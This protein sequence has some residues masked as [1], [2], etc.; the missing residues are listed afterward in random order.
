MLY[1]NKFSQ[2]IIESSTEDDE[3]IRAYNDWK[4]GETRK[5]DNVYRDLPDS[6]ATPK[7]GNYTLKVIPI[8]ETDL[9]NDFARVGYGAR[10]KGDEPKVPALSREYWAHD[11]YDGYQTDQLDM[12]KQGWDTKNRLPI[13]VEETNDNQYEVIDGHH[14]LTIAKELGKKTILALVKNKDM[15]TEDILDPN[16]YLDDFYAMDGMDYYT[17][18]QA[19]DKIQKVIDYVTNL[20]YPI[21]VWRGINTVNPKQ[22]YQGGSWSTDIRVAEGFGNKIFVGLIPSQS[23]IDVEQTIRTRV[24]NPYEY[25]IYVPNFDD[26]E[27]VD[28]YEK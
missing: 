11:D 21:K 23:V 3:T 2:F 4:L 17:E 6:A 1:L 5:V 24:M 7:A 18:E 25:E 28:T 15:E 9:Y 14:R 26:V 20:I 22:D 27:I 12:I 8:S 16:H 13:I 19:L 10:S